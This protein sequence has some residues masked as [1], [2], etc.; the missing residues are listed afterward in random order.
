MTTMMSAAFVFFGIAC[1]DEPWSMKKTTTSLSR[2]TTLWYFEF[3][4]EYFRGVVW[5]QLRQHSKTER[6]TF[7]LALFLVFGDSQSP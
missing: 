3:P 5:P 4:L 2:K 7:P 6:R 1:V